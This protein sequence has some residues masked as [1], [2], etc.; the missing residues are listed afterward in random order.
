MTFHLVKSCKFSFNIRLG[1]NSACKISNDNHTWIYIIVCTEILKWGITTSH[2]YIDTIILGMETLG[3][4]QD[5]KTGA[6]VRYTF[7]YEKIWNFYN[8]CKFTQTWRMQYPTES[9]EKTPAKPQHPPAWVD[10]LAVRSSMILLLAPPSS[11]LNPLFDFLSL[12]VSCLCWNT[13]VCSLH[14]LISLL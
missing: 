10:G 4:T 14:Q 5:G 13:S 1:L 9:L 8:H 6:T 3:K 7:Y 11:R 12:S 2:Q